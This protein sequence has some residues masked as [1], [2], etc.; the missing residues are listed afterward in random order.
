MRLWTATWQI[1]G[2]SKGYQ[3]IRDGRHVGIGHCDDFDQAVEQIRCHRLFNDR[4]HVVRYR[5]R[6]Q[7]EVIVG[8]VPDWRRL[9]R[10]SAR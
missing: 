6:Q 7:Q 4:D 10:G 5:D 3:V 9:A 1:K 2:T 8:A